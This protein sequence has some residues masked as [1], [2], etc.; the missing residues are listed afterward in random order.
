MADALP[1]APAPARRAASP[2]F[3]SSRVA[4]TAKPAPGARVVRPG[5][6]VVD[7]SQADSPVISVSKETSTFSGAFST[8]EVL[9]VLID[10]AGP[11]LSRQDRMA[12]AAGAS[13]EAADLAGGLADLLDAVGCLVADDGDR[14]KGENNGQFQSA[15]TVPGLLYCIAGQ[16]RQIEGM[17]TLA[18][19]A[20][21]LVRMDGAR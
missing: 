14:S 7:P 4:G 13:A 9:A 8:R 10:R 16:L 3:P 20:A 18:S 2:S 11:S 15:A 5:P 19:E 1:G 17:S 12:I 6:A 21:G